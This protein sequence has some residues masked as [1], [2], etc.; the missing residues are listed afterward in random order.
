MSNVPKFNQLIYP[1]VKAIKA[2]GGSG[3]IDEIVDKVIELEKFGEDITTEL[4]PDSSRTELDYNLAWSRTYLKKVGA[5]D[6]S[7]RGIWNLTEYGNKLTEKQCLEIKSEVRKIRKLEKK[8]TNDNVKESL[9]EEISIEE[10]EQDIDFNWKQ[11]L[12]KV[13]MKIDPSAFERLSQRVL[14]ESGFI[15]VEVTGKTNDGG[16]DGIGLLRMNLVSFTVLFQCK[17]YKDTVGAPVV[18]D[19]RGAM[20]GRCDKGLIIT[21]GTFTSEAKKEATRDGAPTID[22]I[23]GDHLCDLI[24]NLKLGLEVELIEK[25]TINEQWF[26][27]I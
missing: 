1:T 3:S 24:K 26:K 27:S 20:Q 2:L 21:T 18:R 12:L 4:H 11:K 5:L 9:S 15:K 22:L 6:N 10:T 14:R 23:D 8:Q 7:G 13:L 19:F 25:I 17:R 16:I